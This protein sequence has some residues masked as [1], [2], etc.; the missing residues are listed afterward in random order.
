MKRTFTPLGGLAEAGPLS[1]A[2]TIVSSEA[3]SAPAVLPLAIALA[4]VI[5]LV[6]GWAGSAQA[7]I[8]GDL[9]VTIEG[10]EMETVEQTG[11]IYI[12]GDGMEPEAVRMEITPEGQEQNAIFITRPEEEVA[13]IV[14]PEL[15]TY[16]TMDLAASGD[17]QPSAPGTGA[18]EME[19]EDLGRATVEGH[20]TQVKG[21]PVVDEQGQTVGQMKVYIA[22]GLDNAPIKS[23]V[24]MQDGTRSESVIRNP[25]KEKLAADLFLPPAGYEETRLPDIGQFMDELGDE[26][27]EGLEEG[28]KEDAREGAKEGARE[29]LRDALPF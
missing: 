28:A 22:P 16:M 26:V 3:S 23:E 10:P 19:L 1:T 24:K 9:H 12:K 5:G 29:G 7:D 8:S 21:G 18:G 17:Q 2:R 15:K 11:R 14:M 13:Y 6:I 4:L 20:R 27:R 25:S